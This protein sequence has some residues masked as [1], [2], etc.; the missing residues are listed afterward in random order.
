ME[1]KLNDLHTHVAIR[2][3]L[4]KASLDG[5]WVS[6][7]PF[8]RHRP[9]FIYNS[10]DNVDEALT[11]K[12]MLSAVVL[13]MDDNTTNTFVCVK[14]DSVNFKLYPV[15]WEEIGFY[16]LGVWYAGMRISNNHPL[17]YDKDIYESANDYVV[18]VGSLQPGAPVCTMFAAFTRN[19]MVRQP[20][21]NYTPPGLCGDSFDVYITN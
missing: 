19:W 21:G 18:I 15:S 8:K 2:E 9:L 7:Q 4:T 11:G 14:G 5:Q 16:I 12:R 10:R 1:K 6:E 3:F 20:D 13:T 17:V